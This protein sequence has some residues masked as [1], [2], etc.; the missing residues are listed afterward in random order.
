MQEYFRLMFTFFLNYS[1]KKFQNFQKC[2]DALK[3]A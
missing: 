1:K 3:K 2:F